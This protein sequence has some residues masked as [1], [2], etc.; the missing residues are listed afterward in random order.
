MHVTRGWEVGV[1]GG[2][3]PNLPNGQCCVKMLTERHNAQ[4]FTHELTAYRG[5][6]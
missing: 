6:P 4:R 5:R 2:G 1:G 3:I